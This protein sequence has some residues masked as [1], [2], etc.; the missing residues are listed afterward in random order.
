MAAK[1][2]ITTDDF[3]SKYTRKR[4]KGATAHVE[5]KEIRAPDG[6]GYDCVFLDRQSMPGKAI[7]SLYKQRPLQCKTWPF[8]NDII[9]TPQAWEAAKLGPEG[10]PGLGKGDVVPYAEIVRLRDM[11]DP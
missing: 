7:C 4:G 9:E 1:L 11:T 5:L 2:T 10:C 6:K 3:Y 8:W